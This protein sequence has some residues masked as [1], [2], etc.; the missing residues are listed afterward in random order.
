MIDQIPSHLQSAVNFGL[1]G[2]NDFGDWVEPFDSIEE[3]DCWLAEMEYLQS[4]TPGAD[5][6]WSIVTTSTAL[7]EL[8]NIELLIRQETVTGE[9]G[10]PYQFVGWEFP[11][12]DLGSGFWRSAPCFCNEVG[13]FYRSLIGT[14]FVSVP[15]DVLIS[16]SYALASDA[17]EPVQPF[18]YQLPRL[19]QQEMA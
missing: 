2:H 10:E 4:N 14:D 18:L 16:P 8:S 12:K 11:A 17:L 3:R 5:Q 19:Q 7:E 9:C 1:I 15:K 6:E 13:W